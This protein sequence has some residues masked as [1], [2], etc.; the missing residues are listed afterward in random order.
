MNKSTRTQN[1]PK[2]TTDSEKPAL[3]ENKPGKQNPPL[4][5]KYIKALRTSFVPTHDSALSATAQ[6]R[7]LPGPLPYIYS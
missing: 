2:P 3:F 1:G 4:Q 6:T 7:G 5:N